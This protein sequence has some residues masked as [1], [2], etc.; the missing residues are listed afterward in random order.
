MNR[1]EN[2]FQ[3]L[4]GDIQDR[5]DVQHRRGN[6]ARLRLT[7]AGWREHAMAAGAVNALR[8]LREFARLVEAPPETR[9]H[10]FEVVPVRLVEVAVC[11]ALDTPDR[12]QQPHDIKVGGH[13]FSRF[14]NMSESAVDDFLRENDVWPLESAAGWL[15]T[16]MAR[17]WQK[18]K[19]FVLT[20]P[21][22]RKG[23]EESAE[24]EPT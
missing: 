12:E 10:E 1:W 6:R 4:L 2:K 5:I 24:E 16:A 23:S 8:D 17:P 14:R 19:W 11:E 18:G 20:T 3:M 22:W 13:Y 15:L 9:E 21:D 7:E